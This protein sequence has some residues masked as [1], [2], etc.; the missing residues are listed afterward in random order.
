MINVVYIAIAV[1]L[2][3]MCFSVWFTSRN[4]YFEKQV[5][6]KSELAMR[7]LIDHKNETDCQKS[8]ELFYK[9]EKL[10]DEIALIIGKHPKMKPYGIDL[11]P[12]VVSEQPQKELSLGELFRQYDK[13]NNHSVIYAKFNQNK[14]DS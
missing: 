14:K 8:I 9:A 7:Y 1:L 13:K 11:P 6:D 3:L 4:R 5:R 10:Q 2:V 12:L